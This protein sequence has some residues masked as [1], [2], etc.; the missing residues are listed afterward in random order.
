MSGQAMMI[1]PFEVSEGNMLACNVPENDHPV[2][3]AGATFN[4]GDRVISTVTHR[5]Y[6]SVANANTARD[7][8]EAGNVPTYWV[9]VGSTNRWRAF[10]KTLG[11]DT[12]KAD[13]IAY[14][15]GLPSRMDAIA[16]VDIVAVALRLAI[17]DAGG[18]TVYDRTVQLLDVSGISSWLDFFT[19]EET[20]DPEVVLTDLGA[21]PG[22]RA[23][24]TISNPGGVAS[25]AEIVAGRSEYIGTILDGTRSGFTG[26]T[27]REVD[28][29]GNISFTKRPTA[30]RAEWEISFETRANRRIQRALEDAQFAPAYFYPGD[31]MTDFFVAIYGIADD[32]F[33]SLSGGGSTQATLTLTGVA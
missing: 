21:M 22:G 29:F 28:E 3:T 14:T 20:Y 31:D 19:Y 15:I 26:Y 32:F 12:A 1:I 8:T 7:P 13:S 11:Q 23:E 24:I 4:L 6:Q 9:E 10:D 2:W 27:R 18:S 25:V 33:P 17:T 5:V 16:F 30:R